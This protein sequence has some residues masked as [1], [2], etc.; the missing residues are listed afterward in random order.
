VIDRRAA[1]GLDYPW[2]DPTLSKRN[3][4]YRVMPDGSV[5]LAIHRDGVEVRAAGLDPHPDLAAL[6]QRCLGHDRASLFA[7]N[8]WQHVLL[9]VD[10]RTRYAGRYDKPL[11]FLL[12]GRITSATAP[13][14]ARPGERWEG[15]RV[16]MRYTLAA[17][18]KDVYAK[19]R[20]AD[21]AETKEHLSAHLAACEPYVRE[22]SRYKPGGGAVYINEARELFGP[23]SEDEYVYLGYVPLD[24]WYPRPTVEDDD[25]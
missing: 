13:R 22:W 6:V 17:T 20:T 12:D 11:R 4:R 1:H 3:G 15:S 14:G 25:Y 21:G 10:G 24:E 16:G 8:E 2:L 7:I 23:L 19:R 5:E 9:K 18:G